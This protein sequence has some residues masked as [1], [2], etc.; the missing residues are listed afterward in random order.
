MTVTFPSLFEHMAYCRD[1]A[2]VLLE[3]NSIQVEDS[4][5]FG[6]RFFRHFSSEVAEDVP[7]QN[8]KANLVFIDCIKN[9]VKEETSEIA[10]LVGRFK[11]RAEKQAPL[12][13]DRIRSAYRICVG[14]FLEGYRK[15]AALGRDTDRIVIGIEGN[16]IVRN[17]GLTDFSDENKRTV[18]AFR[19]S[20]IAEWGHMRVERAEKRYKISLMAMVRDGD[21]LTVDIV[22]CFMQGVADSYIDDLHEAWETLN[23][24]LKQELP[25]S[26]LSQRSLRKLESRHEPLENYR[27]DLSVPFIDLNPRAISLIQDI[28]LLDAH[29]LDLAFQGR[30]LEGIVDGLQRDIRSFFVTTLRQEDLER[31]HMYHYILTYKHDEPEAF[32]CEILVKGLVKKEMVRGMII[33]T[34][35]KEQFLVI[36]EK[37]RT[38]YAK[39]GYYLGG[40]GKAPEKDYLIFRST[41][42]APS[43]TDALS[44]VVTGLNPMQPVGYLWNKEG[45]ETERRILNSSKKPIII[46]GHSLGGTHS[47]LLLLNMIKKVS[48]GVFNS[49]DLPVRDYEIITFDSPKLKLQCATDFARWLESESSEKLHGRIS[50]LHYTSQGDPVPYLGEALLG[51][52]CDATKLKSLNVKKLYPN[53]K[54]E[55]PVIT[56]TH[57]HGRHFFRTV[58]EKDFHERDVPINETT[59]HKWHL[60]EIIRRIVGF[61]LFPVLWLYHAVKVFLFGIGRNLDE[62]MSKVWQM[63]HPHPPLELAEGI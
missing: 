20:L 15:I 35:W 47:Q 57:P 54:S 38:G 34:P 4:W 17:V 13:A 39:L 31:L 12:T 3:E 25:L 19:E 49:D 41:S 46:T 8:V 56:R 40:V 59:C 21:N 10:S 32:F 23:K 26:A 22:N 45:N 9:F 27:Q 6:A 50:I 7:N 60:M 24:I 42:S 51:A 1:K 53:K 5:L 16:Y 62:E 55:E 58:K 14:S 33:P 63:I 28:A 11:K 43:S 61:I 18:T 48:E 29:E 37:L 52:E 44:T 30:R 36:A 2:R